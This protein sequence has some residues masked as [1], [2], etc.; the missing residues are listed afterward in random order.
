MGFSEIWL[1]NKLILA[2]S[3]ESNPV[4]LAH[5][6]AVPIIFLTDVLAVPFMQTNIMTTL[7]SEIVE[8]GYS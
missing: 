4:G 6:V 7:L 2:Y 8:P 3:N 1:E 5:I